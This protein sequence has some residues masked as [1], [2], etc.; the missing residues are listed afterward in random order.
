[1][2]RPTTPIYQEVIMST[3]TSVKPA[4][5]SGLDSRVLART[6]EEGYGSGA[7]HGPD[8]KTALSDVTPELAFW[9]PTRGRHNIAEIALH[10]AYFVRSV[11]AQLSGSAAEPFVLEG[12][13]WFELSDSGPLTWP[14][15]LDVV[16]SQQRQL[17][18]AVSN[19]G[20]PARRRQA[21]PEVEPF[22]IVL[23]IT[24][25][26]VYHAGQVQLIKRLR[27]E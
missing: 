12:E 19:L 15:I 9:R 25:H 18:A 6:I 20:A 26:A 10:H 27:E 21:P 8:L 3:A 13:D 23:G 2:M 11:R 24:C 7:W 14:Q 17:A 22:D 1:M 16:D 5:P 4:T